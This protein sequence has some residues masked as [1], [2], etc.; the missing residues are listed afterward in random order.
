MSES[1]CGGVTSGRTRFRNMVSQ[2]PKLCSSYSPWGSFTE[3]PLFA[4]AHFF[5]ADDEDAP[6]VGELNTEVDFRGVLATA[7]EGVPG[8]S[9]E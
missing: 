4:L 8:M 7:P 2:T 3:R 1:I 6:G 9:F 5:A